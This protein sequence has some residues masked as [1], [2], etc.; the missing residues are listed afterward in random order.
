M[1]EACGRE[2]CAGDEV[3]GYGRQVIDTEEGCEQNGFLQWMLDVQGVQEAASCWQR[4][5]V[6]AILGVVA[7]DFQREVWAVQLFAATYDGG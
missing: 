6:D 4:A 3:G 1:F 7:E 5:E 2:H